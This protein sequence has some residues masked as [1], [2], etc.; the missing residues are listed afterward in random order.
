MDN[1]QAGIV[2]RIWTIGHSTRTPEAL[3]DLLREHSV[4]ALVDVRSFPGSRRYPHFNKEELSVWVPSASIEYI[5]MPV[6]GG[7][8]KPRADSR[9]AA[10][11]NAGFRGYAD[12][13]ETLDF[14]NGV[15][16]L[17]EVARAKPTA[18]MC[19]EALWWRCHRGLIADYLKA[20]GIE[21]IHIIAAGKS[22]DH[23][24]TSAARI[25]EGRLSYEGLMA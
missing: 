1:D 15:E 19:A 14:Q 11:Q 4:K 25:V 20:R 10:W 2:S 13:M 9:N 18:V 7:R 6:L 17:L 21:V 22:E 3:L 12:Y 8:R 16:K 5:H 24:F 23:P